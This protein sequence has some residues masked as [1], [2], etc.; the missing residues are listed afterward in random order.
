MKFKMR[1][2]QYSKDTGA[3]EIATA[4]SKAQGIQKVDRIPPDYNL[5]GERLAIICVDGGKKMDKNVESFVNFLTTD[6]V[7]NIALIGVGTDTA[8]VMKAL[9]DMAKATGINIAGVTECTVKSGLFKKGKPTDSDIQTI[10]AWVDTIV[11]S[12][13]N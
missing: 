11:N 7:K 2:L 3:F 5:E 9:A 4:I 1:V 10:L 12:L 8:D 13:A 6:R